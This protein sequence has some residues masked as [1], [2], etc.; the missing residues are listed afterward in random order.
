MKPQRT[1]GRTTPRRTVRQSTIRR[2]EPV[3]VCARVRNLTKNARGSCLEVADETTIRMTG[4]APEYRVTN[5][6]FSQV[7]NEA[8]NQKIL[9]DHVAYG[10]VDDLILGKHGVL[11]TY[12]V[13]NSGKTYTM[14]GTGEEPGLLPRVIDMIFN[15]MDKLQAKKYVFLPDG[16]NGFSVQSEV[17]A[18]QFRQDHDILPS[19]TSR[20]PA[21][22]KNPPVRYDIEHSKS[23]HAKSDHRYAVFISYVEIYN[24]HVYDLLGETQTD[25]FNRAKT[26]QSLRLREDKHKSMFVYGATQVEV[27]TSEEAFQLLQQGQERK[28]VAITQL[29]AESSRSH[30][31]L[32]VRLVQVPLDPMGEDLLQ[33]PSLIRISQLSLVDLAGSERMSRT[34]VQSGG[35]LREA[36][37]INSSLMTL[38]RCLEQLRSNQKNPASAELVKYRNSKLTYLFKSYFEGRGKVKMVV[39]LNPNMNEYDENVHV[40]QFAETASQVEVV[41]SD[42]YHL[43][44]EN[45]KRKLAEIK[46]AKVEKENEKKKQLVSK[47]LHNESKIRSTPR[48]KARRTPSQSSTES[49]IEV[50]DDKKTPWVSIDYGFIKEIPPVPVIDSADDNTLNDIIKVLKQRI[51]S[52]KDVK[53]NFMEMKTLV[54]ANLNNMSSHEVSTKKKLTELQDKFLLKSKEA[55]RHERNLRKLESKNQVLSKTVEVFEKDNEQLQSKLNNAEAL[56]K[57][58]QQ[59]ARKIDQQMQGVVASTRAE[60]EREA[61]MKVRSAQSELKE[62]MWAKDER[63]RQLRNVVAETSLNTPRKALK[64]LQP[65]SQA[66][67]VSSQQRAVSQTPKPRTNIN[68]RPRPKASD[69]PKPYRRSRSAENILAIEKET[70]PKTA[71]KDT[72]N[73]QDQQPIAGKRRQPRGAGAANWLSHVPDYTVPTDTIFQPRIKASKTV[74]VPTPKDVAKSDNYLLTHQS[75]N[76]P[77]EITTQLVKGEVY[78]TSTGGQQVQFVDI[79]TLAKNNPKKN[80]TAASPSVQKSEKRKS[81]DS[82][83][84]TWTDVETRCAYGIGSSTGKVKKTK[85]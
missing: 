71:S 58:S 25:A 26:P 5:C 48:S 54:R 17:D 2:T 6:K 55:D 30:S 84:S 82:D 72:S 22:S 67:T 47:Y 27:K 41:R 78:A 24:D 13:T 32:N 15:S 56:V 4:P 83:P 33:E 46:A 52:S 66:P 62:K 70:T 50:G 75:G 40:M 11:F 57:S 12:G 73:I 9:F 64:N 85:K 7:F 35:R 20:T 23:T 63:L 1:K 42:D 69:K 10:M 60:V 51:N 76:T 49:S 3:E 77:G 68:A 28:K 61:R 19:F 16:M 74:H 8:V 39:C 31:I 18:M 59:K 53:S 80:Q 81:E 21:K 37:N 79:E 43:D 44:Q 14:S 29:N 36:G 65:S 38:R 34:G 45:L